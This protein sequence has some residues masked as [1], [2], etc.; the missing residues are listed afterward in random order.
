MTR[1]DIGREAA[2]AV[3]IVTTLVA[4]PVGGLAYHRHV[5][6]AK[7]Q[8]RQVIDLCASAREGLWLDRP[9]EGWNYFRTHAKPQPIRVRRGDR[10]ML[11]ITSGDVHH[12]FSIRQLGINTRDVTPGRWTEVEVPTDTPGSY[13]M[14]CYTVCGEHHVY[15]EGELDV[16]DR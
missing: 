11:R 8:G 4:V 12:G 13:T 14:L 16:V 10:V 3:L 9:V 15:M 6:A 2:A 1:I 5:I 7:A